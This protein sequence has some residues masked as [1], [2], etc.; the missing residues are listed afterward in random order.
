M[1]RTNSRAYCPGSLS[2]LEFT[3]CLSM[4]EAEA[5]PR[6]PAGR[7]RYAGCVYNPWFRQ[8]G[9][10]LT[11]KDILCSISLEIFDELICAGRRALLTRARKPY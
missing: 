5:P 6:Q 11:V 1:D 3:L 9:R 7:R 10:I 2:Q 4:C 8:T